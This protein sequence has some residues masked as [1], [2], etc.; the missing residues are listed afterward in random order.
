[1]AELRAAIRPCLV[2][3]IDHQE[4]ALDAVN[5][6]GKKIRCQVTCTPLD[7]SGK[8]PRGVILLMEEVDGE[9]KP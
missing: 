8:E 3:E 2:G 4:V 1:V 6:R 9:K 7:S 5:R